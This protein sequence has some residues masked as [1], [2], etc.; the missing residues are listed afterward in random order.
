VRRGAT[1]SVAPRP[2]RPEMM[3]GAE[4]DGR[5]ERCHTRVQHFH[6]GN[7][8]PRDSDPRPLDPRVRM[9][10]ETKCCSVSPPRPTAP[11]AHIA[12]N[13]YFRTTER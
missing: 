10:H 4:R 7:V 12:T 5:A 8:A 3:S 11:S 2:Q 1:P 9:R 6:L 13:D